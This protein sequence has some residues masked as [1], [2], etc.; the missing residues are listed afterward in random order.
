MEP[1]ASEHTPLLDTVDT[2]DCELYDN[3]AVSRNGMNLD[4]KKKN[5]DLNIY[6]LFYI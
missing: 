5:L 6:F 2:S 4:L 3:L 1:Y